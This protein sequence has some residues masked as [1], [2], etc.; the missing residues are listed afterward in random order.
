MRD[1]PLIQPTVRGGNHPLWVLGHLA[2]IEGALPH[3]LFGEANPVEHWAPLFAPGSQSMTD[4]GTDPPF[5]EV[6]GTFRDLRARNLKRLDEIG[7][8]GLDRLP[9]NVPPGFENEM[10]SFG[11]TMLLIA[12]HQMVHY[13]QITDARRAAG[14]KPLM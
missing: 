10:R 1:A 9:R 3:V 14:R 5:D 4:A 7:D 11:H 6:L 13:G 8:A 12:L 2:Y